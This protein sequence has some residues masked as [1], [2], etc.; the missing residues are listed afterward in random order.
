MDNVF[1]S[2]YLGVELLAPMIVFNCFEDLPDCFPKK[3]QFFT[4]PPVMCKSSNFS[5]F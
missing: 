4:F 1:L 3:L 2:V 5:I